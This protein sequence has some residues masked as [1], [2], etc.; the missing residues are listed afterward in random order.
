[1]EEVHIS[2][3]SMLARSTLVGMQEPQYVGRV[4]SMVPTSFLCRHETIQ[5]LLE[6]EPGGREAKQYRHEE[7]VAFIPIVNPF[8]R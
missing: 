2:V 3:G 1:M 8:S 7:R 5:K 6:A 4:K